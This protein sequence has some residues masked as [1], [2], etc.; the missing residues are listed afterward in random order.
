MRRRS[1]KNIALFGGSFNPPHEGHRE[2]VRRVASRK[3]IDEVWLL[4]VW[5]HPFRKKLPS[6]KKRVKACRHFFLPPL[7]IRGGSG[8]RYEKIRIST[9][10]KRPRATGRTVDLLLYLA[11]KFPRYRFWWVMG[12]DSYRQRRKWKNFGKIRKLARLIVF[13]RGPQSPIPNLASHLLRRK[14]RSRANSTT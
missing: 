12:G 4:P 11:Q 7:K 5:R 8:G 14:S 3:G 13:P 6:F 2:I 9:L 1:S 10:E